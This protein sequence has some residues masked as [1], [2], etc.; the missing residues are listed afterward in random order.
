MQFWGDILAKHPELI[1]ELP[2][3]VV[4]MSWGYEAD[5]RLPR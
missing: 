5:P 3:D 2:E 4:V 1:D